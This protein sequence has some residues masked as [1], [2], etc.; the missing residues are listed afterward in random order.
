MR[1]APATAVALVL[2]TLLSA[3]SGSSAPVASPS[4]APP[5]AAWTL[6]L[7]LDSRNDL[8]AAQIKD[9]AEILESPGCSQVNVLLLA[10]RSESGV[11]DDGYTNDGVGNL[12]DW[13]GCKLLHVRERQLDVIDDWGRVNMAESATVKRFLA[14][15]IARFPAKRYALVFSDHGQGWSGVCVDETAG[16]G[17]DVLDLSEIQEA[18]AGVGKLELIGFDA[19]LMG[20]LEVAATVA[21]FARFMVASEEL[22]PETGWNFAPLLERL[23]ANPDMDGRQLGRDI[24]DTYFASFEES[25]DEEMQ[26]EGIG[27]TLSVVDLEK[28]PALLASVHEM[29]AACHELLTKGGKAAWIK[30]SRARSKAEEYGKSEESEDL[31]YHVFDLADFAK[32]VRLELPGTPAAKDAEAVERDLKAAVT[33]ARHGEGRPRANGLSIFIPRQ[34]EQM[35]GAPGP[36]YG[37]LAVTRGTAWLDFVSTYILKTKALAVPPT[38]EGVKVSADTIKPGAVVKVTGQVKGDGVDECSFVLAEIDEDER[39]Y[40]IGQVATTPDARGRLHEEWDGGWFSISSGGDEQIAPI[41]SMELVDEKQDTWMVQVPVERKRDR[42]W[43]ELTLH[44]L[45]RFTDEGAD[46]RFVYA[47]REAEAGPRQVRLRK[48]DVLRPCFIEIDENGDELLVTSED[49]A[50]YLVLGKAGGLEVDYVAVPA[51]T[52]EVGFLASDPSGEVVEER[53]PVQ[54]E[55]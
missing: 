4:P 49:P 48:G 30:L 23:C 41:T 33:Y 43:E 11:E 27:S 46:G 28:V 9:I 31:D 47:F 3:C 42:R 37:Q 12:P 45:V 29:A 8:E 36:D 20:N 25:R 15:G 34:K 32:R 50:D 6:M 14:A 2:A 17:D 7:Y 13:S 18:L 16:K 39:V 54:V 19:C 40:I 1:I 24:V 26:A 44:F 35:A 55:D 22:E 38:L 10:A 51:G 52:Y 21:P 53:V 5:T